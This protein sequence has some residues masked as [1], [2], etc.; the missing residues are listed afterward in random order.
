MCVCVCV[1]V[2]VGGWG[3]SVNHSRISLIS[4]SL[5]SHVEVGCIDVIRAGS[6]VLKRQHHT[7]VV[8]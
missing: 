5:L 1:C 2:C 8:V 6:V 3:G 4:I 7:R